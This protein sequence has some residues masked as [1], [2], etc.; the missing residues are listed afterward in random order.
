VHHLQKADKILVLDDG[1]QIA[2]GTYTELIDKGMNINALLTANM[3]IGSAQ[4][5]KKMIQKSL[6]NAGAAASSA[7]AGAIVA[8]AIA[9]SGTSGPVACSGAVG[10]VAKKSELEK[11]L[12]PSATS[13]GAASGVQI[14]VADL[15]FTISV[16]FFYFFF[17]KCN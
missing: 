11:L 3:E 17:N 7:A 15:Y 9:S 10:V 14:E 5:S 12:S 13:I 2:C 1:D 4:V 16:F 6:N 8:G